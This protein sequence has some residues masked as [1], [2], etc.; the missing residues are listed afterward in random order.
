M[1]FE[2]F[3]HRAIQVPLVGALALAAL[4]PLID[5][6]GRGLG[7]FHVP[8]SAAYVQQL[9]LWLVFLGG[10]V[11]AREGKHLT[12]S[13]ATL[14]GEGTV[15]RGTHMFACSVAAATAGVLA[16]G[17]AT[18]VA[19]NRQS[20]KLL[21]IG[22]PEWISECIMPGAL[23]LIAARYVAQASAGWGGRILALAAV[24]GT[25]A[26]GLLPVEAVSHTWPLTL[27]VVAGALL[28]A[29]VF[30]AMGGLALVLFFHDG[31]PVSAVP[32]EV[33]RL[34]HSPTLPAIPLLTTCGYVLAESQASTRLVRLFHALLGWMPGGIAVMVAVVCALFTTLT[35]GSGVTIIALGGL[36]YPILRK[37]AY[38][39]NF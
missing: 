5:A 34:I 3:A 32:A 20:G 18:L 6:V 16:Y 17:S 11:A 27:V 24:G 9:T 22:L 30:I 2:G 39:E 23:A 19:V 28:G 10:L 36:V 4:L 8:G 7:G 25:L 15:R 38:S 21:P 37:S 26:L 12:L 1:R 35:G 29:P 31:T 33:Y 13:T 14:L